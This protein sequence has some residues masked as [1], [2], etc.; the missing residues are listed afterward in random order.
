MELLKCIQV[1]QN[2]IMEFNDYGVLSLSIIV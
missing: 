1:L 2:L